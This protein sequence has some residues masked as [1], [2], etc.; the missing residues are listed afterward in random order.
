MTDKL[1]ETLEQVDRTLKDLKNIFGPIL[2]RMEQRLLVLDHQ[3]NR[4]SEELEERNEAIQ[5]TV[6]SNGN[7]EQARG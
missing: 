1:V 5:N 4:I 7:P 2:F 6:R 3:L